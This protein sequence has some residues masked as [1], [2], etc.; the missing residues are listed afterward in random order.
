MK[1]KCISFL[2]S[3]S[4]VL[5]NFS[6]FAQQD[7]EIKMVIDNPTVV[8]NGEESVIDVPPTILNGRTM[9]PIRFVA[10]NLGAEVEWDGATRTVTI[11]MPD[12][13]V[14]KDQL[15]LIQSELEELEATYQSRIEGLEEQLEVSVEQ[16][17]ELQELIN[18]IELAHAE[19]IQELEEKIEAL[20]ELIEELKDKLASGDNGGET[21]LV[22]E[23]NPPIITLLNI[24]EGQN[25]AEEI[26]LEGKI[27][28]ESPIA[29]VRTHLGTHLLHEGRT[30]DGTITPSMFSSGEYTLIV[31][32]IDAFGNIGTSSII[33]NIANPTR[34]E[35]VTLNVKIMD[36]S[37]MGQGSFLFSTISNKSSSY[38]EVLKI[39][40][41]KAD[42]DL[43]EIMPGV[44]FAE[45]MLM[46]FE[47]KHL[48][49][50]K[51]DRISLPVAMDMEDS[52]RPAKDYFK[53]WKVR[54]TLYD[55][56]MQRE[57]LLETTYAG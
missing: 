17:T 47:M 34:E 51:N 1:K 49:I 45:A 24:T 29:F 55:F 18:A 52:G 7:I 40:V 36:L 54:V 23:S 13:H 53:N 56:I 43:F 27:E 38:I 16:I 42:G 2:L 39:E 57:L 10:E 50:Q 11:R 28:D 33:V 46:Q 5:F 4:I 48:L 44:G 14:L 22:E 31:E 37:A 8:V 12:P 15:E 19:K 9:V 26:K 21:G 30:I 41:F 32:A 6:A 25:I 20:E 35:P 3:L